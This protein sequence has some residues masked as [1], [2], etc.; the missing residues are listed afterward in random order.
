MALHRSKAL[1][2]KEKIPRQLVDYVQFNTMVISYNL[3]FANYSL[4]KKH[5]TQFIP[6]IVWKQVYMDYQTAY[7]YSYLMEKTFKDRLRDTLKELEIGISNQEGSEKAIVQ[8]DQVL[9]HLKATNGHATRNI[10]KK[11]KV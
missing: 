2:P 8:C 5:V 3:H 1:H 9:E 6:I 10:F 4:G 11:I 7:L